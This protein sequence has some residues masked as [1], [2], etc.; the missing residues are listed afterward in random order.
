MVAVSD[1]RRKQPTFFFSDQVV[2]VGSNHMQAEVLQ[3]LFDSGDSLLGQPAS[4]VG[5]RLG[6]SLKDWAKLL[7]STSNVRST[8]GIIATVEGSR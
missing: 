7:G 5:I 1:A 8:G 3:P 6:A 4:R 2:V